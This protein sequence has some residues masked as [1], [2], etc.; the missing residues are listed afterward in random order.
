M[1]LFK[2]FMKKLSISVLTFSRWDWMIFEMSVMMMALFLA[3]VIPFLITG[4]PVWVYFVIFIL[5]YT[6]LLR[7]F[8]SKAKRLN[9]SNV[10]SQFS[11]VASKFETF[12]WTTYKL[13]IVGFTLMLV[14]WAPILAELPWFIYIIVVL[15]LMIY[16]FAKV[17]SEK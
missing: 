15:I 17:F 5:P 8:F 11:T 10:V 2:M 13:C 7:N 6:Y 4:V 9:T 1:K 16:F 14:T 12:D 3:S